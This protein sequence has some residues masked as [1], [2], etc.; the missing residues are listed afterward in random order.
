MAGVIIICRISF[1][2]LLSLLV[3]AK[4]ISTR[5]P[6]RVLSS[7]G[8]SF[9]IISAILTWKT[10]TPYELDIITSCVTLCL[11]S[12]L[13]YLYG[14]INSSF[15]KCCKNDGKKI[16]NEILQKVCTIENRLRNLEK[17]LLKKKK[18]SNTI[19]NLK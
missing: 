7:V 8:L 4:A 16:R 12:L 14:A 18:E 13:V 2:F 15:G 6:V 5:K 17:K 1:A 19:F 10:S 11:F 3:S 9:A